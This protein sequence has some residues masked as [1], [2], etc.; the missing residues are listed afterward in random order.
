MR[1]YFPIWNQIKTTGKATLIAPVSSRRR[2]IQA[3]RKERSNDR[4]WRLLAYEA[5]RKYQLED[6]WELHATS[7]TGILTFKL[8]DITGITIKDL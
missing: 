5:G 1:Q 7:D 8:V 4:G 3:V 6:T 2:I